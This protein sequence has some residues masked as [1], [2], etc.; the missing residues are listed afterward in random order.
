MSNADVIIEI[1]EQEGIEYLLGFPNNRLFNS[2]ASHSIRPIIARTERV[3]I[4][5]A[6]AYTRMN[7]GARI[8]VVAVQDGPG[9]EASFPAVAQAYGDNTPILML[10]GAHAPAMQDYDPQFMASR[11]FRD[12]THDCQK[13][14]NGLLGSEKR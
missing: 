10:P 6:D 11:S 13:A 1:L 2:A 5:M 4:N 9:I 8:G 12:I 14:G 7:N 3:A